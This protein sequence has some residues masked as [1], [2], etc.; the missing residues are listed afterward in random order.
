MATA[1]VEDGRLVAWSEKAIFDLPLE[2]PECISENY[3]GDMADFTY[4]DGRVSFDP[5]PE[6]QRSRR[7]RE[8]QQALSDTDYYAA[9]SL[10]GLVECRTPEEITAW[11][12]SVTERYGNMIAQRKAWREELNGITAP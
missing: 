7:R 4:S 2:N 6:T 3:I 8:L 11:A 10:E 12:E 9:R 1:L 5:S